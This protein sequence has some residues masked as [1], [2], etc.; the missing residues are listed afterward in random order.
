MIPGTGNLLQRLFGSKEFGSGVFSQLFGGNFGGAF[1][2]FFGLAK[3]G[4]MSY[5]RGGIAKQPTYMVGE[6]KQHEAVV[7]LPDNKSI[8]VNLKGANANNN[9]NVSVNMETGATTMDSSDDGFVLGQAISAAVI[10][11]IERQQRPGGQLSTF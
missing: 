7:P 1:S 10:K 9:V 11:E 8:P 6:G 4:I 5:G 2:T 3:G